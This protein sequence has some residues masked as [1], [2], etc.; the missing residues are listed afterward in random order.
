MSKTAIVAADI[1]AA[2]KD[3]TAATPSLRTLGTGAQQAA[4]GND[5]RFTPYG[6]TLPLQPA[7]GNNMPFFYTGAGYN[8]T[9]Y[10]NGTRWLST[11]IYTSEMGTVITAT[12]GAFNRIATYQNTSVADIWLVAFTVTTLPTAIQNGSNYWVFTFWKYDISDASTVLGTFNSQTDGANLHSIHNL[13][14]GAVLGGAGTY[15]G[16]LGNIFSAGS[17]GTVYA[18]ARVSYRKIAT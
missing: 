3:G 17:P 18:T 16:L 12:V 11:T 14:I 4:A 8:E 13:T 1:A 10:Y 5:T 15:R 6:P 2:N 7:Y 9:V